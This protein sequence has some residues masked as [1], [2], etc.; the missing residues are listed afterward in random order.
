MRE[1]ELGKRRAI[2]SKVLSQRGSRH[3]AVACSAREM[4]STKMADPR[5]VLLRCCRACVHTY[6]RLDTHGPLV[7]SVDAMI[8]ERIPDRLNDYVRRREE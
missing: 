8:S 7:L 5:A 4:T 3:F 1:R 2:K 6:R